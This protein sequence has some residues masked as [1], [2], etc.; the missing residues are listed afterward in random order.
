MGDSLSYLDNPF[1]LDKPMVIESRT[2]RGYGVGRGTDTLV[3][4]N[5]SFKFASTVFH[6]PVDWSMK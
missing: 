1:I 6:F 3:Q 4:D 5:M 2:F